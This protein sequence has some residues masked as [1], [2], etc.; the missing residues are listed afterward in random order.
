MQE[1]TRSIE[2]I[3]PI[4]KM[5]LTISQK[6]D[7]TKS[8]VISK[9]ENKNLNLPQ[10]YFGDVIHLNLEV[11]DGLG[12][13]A[14]FLG[15]SDVGLSVAIGD[16]VTRTTFASSEFDYV[17]GIY[18]TD[19]DLNTQALEDEIGTKESISKFLEIKLSTFEGDTHTLLQMPI[20]IQNQLIS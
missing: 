17:G 19:F 7:P 12:G 6:N 13:S 16:P 18:H 1:A 11:V 14:D 8:F 10:V 4:Q 5:N 20:K 15:R 9:T 2:Q 3:F